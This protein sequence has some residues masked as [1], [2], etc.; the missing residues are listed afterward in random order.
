[1]PCTWPRSARS[2]KLDVGSLGVPQLILGRRA[3]GLRPGGAQP[4]RIALA[5]PRCSI[6]AER[7]KSAPGA[8]AI[9]PDNGVRVIESEFIA[10]FLSIATGTR[11]RRRRTRRTRAHPARPRRQ[12]R[13]PLSHGRSGAADLAERRAESLRPARRGSAR[14]HRRHADRAG[15]EYLPQ[16]RSS[17]SSAAFPRWWNSASSSTKSR[18]S[19]ELSVEIEDRLD[20]PQRVAQELRLRLGLTVA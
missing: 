17:R 1:M 3:G 11:R 15:S 5:G 2:S 6:I 19:I 12:P 10:E 13:D 14:P 8:T 18:N 4:H 16:S 7:P 20:H 9:C